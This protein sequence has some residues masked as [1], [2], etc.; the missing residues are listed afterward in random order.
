MNEPPRKLEVEVRQA[1]D[2]RGQP[3]ATSH[4]QEIDRR[5]RGPGKWV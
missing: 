5:C 2:R 3:R 4:G 1:R